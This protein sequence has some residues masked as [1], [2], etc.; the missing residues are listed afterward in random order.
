MKNKCVECEHPMFVDVR[1]PSRYHR[2]IKT[3]EVE[4]IDGDI[5]DYVDI[6]AVLRAFEVTDQAIGHAIKKLLDGGNRGVKSKTQD[7][8]EAVMSIQAAIKLEKE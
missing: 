6:Y 2:K 7:W 4:S 5:I 8:E 3:H 1:L